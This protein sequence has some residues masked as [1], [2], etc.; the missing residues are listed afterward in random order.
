MKIRSKTLCSALFASLLATAA[1]GCDS[2]EN[3]NVMENAEQ[4]KID[5]YNQMMEEE[6]KAMGASMNEGMKKK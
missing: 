6:Q 4:S 5:E 2:G 3:T 1:V